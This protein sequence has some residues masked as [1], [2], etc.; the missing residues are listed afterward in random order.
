MRNFVQNW[1]HIDTKICGISCKTTQ[2]LRKR[3]DCFV[4]T[5]GGRGGVAKFDLL[6][7]QIL[8]SSARIDKVKAR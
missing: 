1:F 8:F 2:L 3:I 5:L 7:P 6:P 4:K